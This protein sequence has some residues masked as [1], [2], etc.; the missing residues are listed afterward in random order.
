MSQL[1]TIALRDALIGRIS[2][3]ALDDHYV[4]DET[5]SQALRKIW[6][7]P[8]ETGGLGSDLWVEGAF[9]STPASETMQD[10]IN[11]GLIHPDLG[12][13]LDVTGVFPLTL[14]PYQHQLDSFEAASS[15]E[16]PS[17]C[18]PGI[19]VTAG[20]GAGKTESFLIPM[21]NELWRSPSRSGEGVSAL[22]LY[23]M[24]AL[25][26]DQVGRLDK[27]LRGQS[28]VSSFHFTSETPENAKLA[29]NR[30]LPPATASRF[31]TRQQA[32]G[33]EDAQGRPLLN[34]D[35]PNP[36][37]LVTNY[38][39]LEY[40]LCRPQ[41]SVFF[42]SN[43]RVVILDEAHI[44]S[45]NLAAEITLLLRRVMMRCGRSPEKVLCMATSATIGGGIEELKP[46]AAKLFS[47]PEELVRV[48][49][50]RPQRPELKAQEASLPLSSSLVDA[51]RDH[52]FPNEET[53]I[54]KDGESKFRAA[55]EDGWSTWT[56]ALSALVPEDE[57]S[58]AV[59][60]QSE[61]RE[62]APLL[63]NSLTH[64]EAVAAL[65]GVLWN[66]G[67]PARIPLT[68]LSERVFG[69]T[70]GESLEAIRQILQV[71]AIARNQ[72][73]AL[74]LVPNRMHYLLR[75][76]EGVMMSFGDE[77]SE[78]MVD[79]SNGRQVFSAG[80]DPAV[81]G[82][83]V[84]HPL[85]VFRCNESGWWG[86][87]G[88]LVDGNIQPVPQ[89]VILYGEDEDPDFDPE[90]PNAPQQGQTRYFSLNE[91][92]GRPSIR[93]DPATGRYGAAG[94]VQLWEVDACPLS[95]ISLTSVSVGWFSSRARLQ[96]S[97]VA[98][99]ALAAMPEYP[100]DNKA[101]KPARGRRLLVF[102]D[103]RAEA[104]RLGPRLTRQHELQVFRAAVVERLQN[105]NLVATDE[106]LQLLRDE[107][108]N[109]R[110]QI[111]AASPARKL[112][113]QRRLDQSEQDLQQMDQGGTVADWVS[114]LKESEIIPE[115]FD[116][117]G[118]KDHLPGD[119]H[120]HDVW[121]S[122]SDAVRDSLSSLL[123]RE[124]ARRPTWPWPSLETLGLVEVVYP[125]I[126]SLRVPNEVLGT[127]PPPVA[128]KLEASWGDYLSALL[129]AVR[130]QGA[131]TLGS[132]EA[133][134]D[135]QYGNGLL[136]KLFAQE[137]SYRRSMIPLLGVHVDGP[138]ASRR[139]AF[140]KQVLEAYGLESSR[141]SEVTRS[142]IRAAFS[143]LLRAAEGGELP[144]MAIVASAPTND[145]NVVPALR[146]RF[147]Q[148]ALRRPARLFQCPHT[149]Q[150]WP[151]SVAGYY[152]GGNSPTLAEISHEEIDN[153]PR[154][155]RRRR[156]LRDW[157][158]FK[159]GL[160]AEE[161]SA[162]LSPDEN[163]RLQNLFR[164]GMRNIL[165]STT[166]LEL[167]I[168]IGGL[169]AVLLGNLPPGKANYLQRAGRAGRRADGT[170]AVLGFARPSAY[171]REVFL[172]FRRYL[173]RDLRKPTVFLDRAPLVIRHAHAWLLGGF[174]RVHF[175]QGAASGTMDAYGRMGLFT[176]Q[177]LPDV[178]R[179]GQA[180]PDV[181]APNPH[182]IS[183]QFLEYLD[184]LMGSPPAGMQETLARLWS[185]CPNVNSDPSAWQDNLRAIRE[186]FKDAIEGWTQIVSELVTTWGEIPSVAPQ[187]TGSGP[188]RAQAN[189][190]FFQLLA[191]HRLTVIE[192]LADA[193]VL[194]RYGFPIG[195]SRLRVQVSDDGRRTREED[196][197][198]LQRDGMMAMREYTPGSQLLVGGMVITSRG[199]L[200][201]WTGAVMQSESW[202][203]RG[204]FVKTSG[205]YFDYSLS[206]SPPDDPPILGP[207][208][209]VRRG[210]FLFPKHGFTTAAWDP[211]RHGSDFDRIGELEVFTLAFSNAADCDP[212]QTGFGGITGCVA[213]YRDAGEL[214]LMNSGAHERGFA[215]C[216]KCGYAESEWQAGAAGRVDLPSRFESHAPLNAADIRMRCW[217]ADEAPAW[218]NHHLAAKQTTNLLKLD[219]GNVGQPMDRELLYTLGQALRLTA[220]ETLELDEREIG[221]L[222]PVPDPMT[223][224]YR[225][226]VLYDS[227]AGGSGHLAELSHPDKPSTGQ[228]WLTRTISLLTVEGEMSD[229]VRIREAVRRLLTSA[230]ND[231]LICPERALAFLASALQSSGGHPAASTASQTVEADYSRVEDLADQSLPETFTLAIGEGEISGVAAGA[232]SLRSIQPGQ[233]S[234]LPQA[235]QVVVVKVPGGQ[236]AIGKWLYQQTTDQQKPH[237][238]RLR[239][240]ISP[241]TLELS[242]QEFS[243]LVLIAVANH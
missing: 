99:T 181:G 20:T 122:N 239:R 224:Q 16:Y 89:S 173:E 102:S 230:C 211:P 198:R 96:L 142:V 81:L 214:L 113:L 195:L 197:F 54:N 13:Q 131:V 153:D 139:N 119:Q 111:E 39:M 71:G 22:I 28:R 77:S 79:I 151:R 18:K 223:G 225:S 52:P 82:E 238:V 148:L 143:C 9:P 109:I 78:G 165:S 19:V 103:S 10:L 128:A 76:P 130:G 196:Q 32:R 134:R 175:L 31:R 233:E 160:W 180:K 107:I 157:I 59:D 60:T 87:A 86:V 136:G 3:F 193:R 234:R 215:I 25:V 133:D 29:N 2:D 186:A 221:M 232:L 67:E 135:Y 190:I 36:D 33:R 240:L 104:A 42:G 237:R 213:T 69:R 123:G 115:L 149:G 235:N 161:H 227:L 49:A 204:R 73:S 185:G 68:E 184:S 57:L 182:P 201:H 210:E 4:R 243:Q 120:A 55:T 93:F 112:I 98:E 74:P 30:N 154:L 191:L 228:E 137:Q 8:P 51:L 45:G 21:L 50:G 47:K 172:D 167:G 141:V 118:G 11:R 178:W 101:W 34:G 66:D 144:W 12:R 189:A 169:S 48:I 91:I 15:K 241:V 62:A 187:A 46:F 27:W 24:N 129:D 105:V 38:S 146:I 72:P 7:G 35:G 206:S 200:K 97:V 207:G 56:E 37:I 61:R 94:D 43:L 202:G 5:L 90:N 23:P 70:D 17:G 75:G 212:P 85:T 229:A 183:E 6:S 140:T 220:A 231:S 199:L 127:L 166:T 222:D 40:M 168:D 147:Q 208:G 177:P 205:G 163:A 242:E 41:D 179:P 92:S 110:S 124:L 162:Q 164:E 106:E 203:L 138:Q 219:F 156:E 108:E 192:A 88:K 216:Q 155:G 53:L 44:Y 152:P 159:L 236:L 226:V 26:N 58:E 64:S 83:G 176:G 171:E 14:N 1:N 158:G 145:D 116:A 117:P 126:S 188:Y 125:G 209:R 121:T 194:P 63:A 84:R 150:V 217:A 100:D 95:G 132:Q 65:Q 218:R 114:V 174:F 170:S 80:A